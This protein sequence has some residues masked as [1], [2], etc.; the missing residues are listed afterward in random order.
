M[1]LD[2]EPKTR[3]MPDSAHATVDDGAPPG[4]GP[5]SFDAAADPGLRVGQRWKDLTLEGEVSGVPWCF[6]ANHVGL[7]ETVVVRATPIHAG[8]EWRRGAWERLCALT[9]SK[10]VRCIEAHEESGWRF[11][12]TALPPPMTLREWMAAHRPGFSDIENFVRQIAGVLGALHGHGVVHLNIRPESIFVDESRGEPV[13]VLGGLQEATLYTQPEL[14]LADVD[15]FYAPPEAMGVEE[16]PRGTGLCAWD[17]WSVGRV[18][19]EFLIGK[20]VLGVLLDRDVSRPTP[21][22]RRHAEELLKETEIPDVKAGALELT[23]VDPGCTALLRGLLSSA[24]DGRWGLD[25][26]QRWLRRETV[27]DHYDLPRGTRMWSWKGRIFTLAEAVEFFTQAKHWAEGE[28]MLFHPQEKETLAH[29]LSEVPA[30][31]EDWERLQRVCDLAEGSGWEQLPMVAR[32]PVTAAVAWL[33]LAAGAGARPTFRVCGHAI[34]LPGVGELLKSGG[35]DNG[36]ALVTALLSPAVIEAVEPHDVSAARVLKAVAAKGAAAL[37]QASAI[38]WLDADDAAGQARMLELSLSSAAVLREKVD[39]LRATHATNT[40]ATVAQWFAEKSLEPAELVLL[41]YAAEAPERHGFVTHEEWRRRQCAELREQAAVIGRKLA[42]ARLRRV[43]GIARPWGGKPAVFAGWVLV[44]TAVAGGL[45]RSAVQPA[46]V[47]GVL[48]GSRAWVWWRTRRLLER[49]DTLAETWVWGDGWQRCRTEAERVAGGATVR[50]LS[51]Q[52]CEIRERVEK[53]TKGKGPPLA[54]PEPKVW[55]VSVVLVAAVCVALAA[56]VQPL[57]RE[58]RSEPEA[59]RRAEPDAE[60]PLEQT[61][62]EAPLAEANSPEALL[63]TGRYEVVDDGFGRRLR[64]PLEKWSFRPSPP[65][66]PLKVV[67]QAPASADQ[68][69]FARVSAA[70]LLHPYPKKGIHVYLAVRVP[71]TRGFGVMIFNAR[72]RELASRDV[73]LLEGALERET[74]HQWGRRRVFY[75]GAPAGLEAE[76]SLAPP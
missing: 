19:Q 20:H 37:R 73:L 13:Y 64:G 70:V 55:N 48:L 62:I 7:M 5:S 71:T 66:P 24:V 39:L 30:H 46:V 74:W 51:A 43:L 36:V 69:A 22:L 57:V 25:A 68:S 44:L 60:V 56:L 26:V 31:R 59:E 28:D 75:L 16:H 10:V 53:L 29:F 33:V 47:A 17:W 35:V 49:F 54:I 58:P 45:A 6:V 32:R 67:A 1:P 11:E 38:G 27:R 4:P 21:E 42:W 2:E 76:F 61:V 14:T 18:V 41:A 34:D 15:P 52:L 9:D 63:V 8:T 40:N 72:D 23:Q 3:L 65:V 50:E 12:I